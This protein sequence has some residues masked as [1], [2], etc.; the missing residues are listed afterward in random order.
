MGQN[1][2]RGGGYDEW[3]ELS[4]SNIYTLFSGKDGERSIQCRIVDVE[5]PKG[6]TMTKV[7]F[8]KVSEDGR[9]FHAGDFSVAEFKR[10]CYAGMAILGALTENK[11]D[12]YDR[13]EFFMSTGDSIDYS[14]TPSIEEL[15][16]GSAFSKKRNRRNTRDNNSRGRSDGGRNDNRDGQDRNDNRRNDRSRS[17]SR[18]RGD[19]QDRGRGD[20]RSESRR[21][22]RDDDRNNRGRNSGRN[23]RSR[24]ESRDRGDNRSHGRSDRDRNRD[25]DGFSP[26]PGYDDRDYERSDDY[27]MYDQD[28]KEIYDESDPFS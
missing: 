4:V 20:S 18:D 5:T 16:D 1:N 14:I 26:P 19:R 3:P 28:G 27:P 17:E 6:N 2:N 25:D 22:N 13:P 7:K 23:D 10:M 9:V 8:S 21:D 12:W 24:S 11:D 15:C